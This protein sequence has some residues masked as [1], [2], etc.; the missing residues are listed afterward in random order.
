MVD[1]DVLNSL[2]AA[3]WPRAFG[4]LAN[5]FG[6]IDQEYGNKM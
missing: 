5:A 4:R 6:S 3:K 2:G 1:G